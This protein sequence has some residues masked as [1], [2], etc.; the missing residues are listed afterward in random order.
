LRALAEG[1][2]PGPGSC[3][4]LHRWSTEP[5]FLDEFAVLAR[6]Y[7]V[8]VLDLPGRRRHDGSW[9]PMGVDDRVDDLAALRYWVPDIA[10]RDVYVC[11]PEA[12]TVLVRATLLRAG[13]PEDRL[14][15]ET[16]GW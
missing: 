15:L 1:L 12:W 2:R 8:N 5:L 9:L 7:G 10:E 16:F 13:L 14:H 3:V 11:G 6:E 4:V